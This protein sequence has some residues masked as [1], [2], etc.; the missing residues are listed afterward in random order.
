M[1]L[2]RIDRIVNG[3]RDG[4]TVLFEDKEF[5]VVQETERAAAAI[6][7]SVFLKQRHTSG[8][9]TLDPEVMGRMMLRASECA[10][11]QGL[12]EGYRVVMD[13]SVNQ[14]HCQGSL[15]NVVM[16]VIGG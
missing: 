11:Q 2:S 1:D 9:E 7:F 5:L 14:R 12:A 3:E 6:H 8:I 15:Q 10:K 4:L 13:R 16:H